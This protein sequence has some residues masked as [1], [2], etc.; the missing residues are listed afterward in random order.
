MGIEHELVNDLDE[1]LDDPTYGIVELGITYLTRTGG[2]FDI[3]YSV[4]FGLDGVR[5]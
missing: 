5:K 3:T 4:R 1:F 2:N